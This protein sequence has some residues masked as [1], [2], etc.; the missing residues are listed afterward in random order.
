MKKKIFIATS[1]FGLYSEEIYKLLNDNFTI[2]KNNTG[3]K[4]DSAEL[5]KKLNEM[6]GVIAGTELYNQD[7]LKN[8]RSLKIISR[9]G[10]GIDNLDVKYLNE[11]GIKF[12]ITNTNPSLAVAELVLGF[13]I[14]MNRNILLHNNDII[15]GIWEKKMKIKDLL[16]K[17]TKFQMIK[18]HF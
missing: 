6:D 13:I 8:N 5:S 12:K 3:R 7:V 18:L 17:I 14:M 10:V 16:I 9:L 1:S 15:S 4:L 11:K 2:T